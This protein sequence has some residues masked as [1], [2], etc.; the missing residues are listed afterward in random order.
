MK[1]KKLGK[2][3]DPTE[4]KLPN[5]CV[6]YAQSPQVIVKDDFIRIYFS[7]RKIDPKNGKFLSH[8]SFVDVDKTF[9]NIIKTAD[10]TVIPLGKLGA[11]DE[12][13]IFPIN[14]LEHNDEIFAYTCGWNRRSS[15]SV[16]TGIGFA[17]SFDGGLTFEK[18]GDGPILGPSINEPFLV[19]DAFVKKYNNIFHMWYMFGTKWQIY[20]DNT[21]PDRTYKIGHATSNDGI[22]WCK[23][24]GIQAVPDKL[25]PDE[26]MALPTVVEH[27]SQ[28]HM[29]FCYR[30]SSDFRSV[31]SRGYRI[32]Y[33]FSDD[34]IHWTRDD[35]KVG[36][37]VSFDGWDSEMLC[38]PHLFK[39]DGKVYLLYNGNEFGRFGFGLAV[40][41]D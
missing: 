21:A 27:D 7:T 13:G 39:C 12:H 22:N 38:Y 24:D 6:E 37:D 23:E 8:V 28:Y 34:L 11:F 2:I 20:G 18:L 32:G 3:F 16:D 30:E 15:V 19:G 4:H 26:S 1:W 40:L 36:I 31:S 41:E 5:N 10:E 33:A 9:K 14:L 35:N 29:L 25:N 17:R